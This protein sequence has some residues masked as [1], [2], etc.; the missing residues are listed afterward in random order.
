MKVVNVVKWNVWK[1][2]DGDGEGWDRLD[3]EIVILLNICY[4]KIV[5]RRGVK[6]IVGFWFSRESRGFSYRGI[7]IDLFLVSMV[8]GF[9]LSCGY[10]N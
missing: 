4:I 1:D 7:F 3:G 8:V 2:I 6:S 9:F 10:K 5:V